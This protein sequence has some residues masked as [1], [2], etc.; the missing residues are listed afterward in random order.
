MDLKVTMVGKSGSGKSALMSGMF[1]ELFVDHSLGYRIIGS[2]RSSG[3]DMLMSA[4][5]IKQYLFSSLNNQFPPS[6]D[7]TTLFKFDFVHN[8]NL[9]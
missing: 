8:G 9:I 5:D 6:T 1:E 2:A 4:G 3:Y 7:E